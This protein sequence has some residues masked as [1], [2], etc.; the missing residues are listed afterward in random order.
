MLTPDEKPPEKLS[1]SPADPRKDGIQPQSRVVMWLFGWV[2]ARYIRRQFHAVRMA[3]AERFRALDQP[4]IVCVNHP[5]WWD[6]LTCITVY[7]NL[8]PNHL[9]YAPMDADALRQYGFFRKIGLFP[10]EMGTARGAA[11]FLRGG[12]EVLANPRNV[13]W[14]T[15]QGEFT[16]QRQRPTRFKP[17]LGALVHRMGSCTVL[18]LAIEY[19]YWDQR[20]P[21]VLLL[22]GAP[23]RV[24]NS[25]ERTPAEWTAILEDALEAAQNE[26]VA[27]AKD[28]D[29]KNFSTL[30]AGG[31]GVGGLY[32]LWQRLRA[33]MRGEAYKPEHHGIGR[34]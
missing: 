26:L 31:V 21:E 8:M 11:Q 23:V 22:C 33:R 24:E 3:H 17:G 20:L 12:R 27:L 9:H 29:A 2:I 28:R 30:A 15:P 5:S 6:P 18:P 16:D 10:I 1:T 13:L 34:V 7:R 25:R 32:Q 4:L 14:V 19:T